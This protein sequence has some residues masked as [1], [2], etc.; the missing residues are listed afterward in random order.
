MA[1]NALLRAKLLSKLYPED[2]FSEVYTPGTYGGGGK[3]AC[4]M[5][6]PAVGTYDMHVQALLSS[7]NAEL[8]SMNADVVTMMEI[9]TDAKSHGR[10]RGE[11]GNAGYKVSVVECQTVTSPRILPSA[12]HN[13]I[14]S[15][16]EHKEVM[17]G[18]PGM[19]EMNVSV[20]I[21][22]IVARLK[23]TNSVWSKLVRTPNEKRSGMI[24]KKLAGMRFEMERYR[25]ALK[26]LPLLFEGG[27]QTVYSAIHDCLADAVL[28]IRAVR[29]LAKRHGAPTF[30]V[31]MEPMCTLYKFAYEAL[32][33][34]ERV[35]NE[36]GTQVHMFCPEMYS[37]VLALTHEAITPL[38]A[39]VPEAKT[40]GF[41]FT[42]KRFREYMLEASIS[43]HENN[44]LGIGF[45][46]HKNVD[47]DE[48]DAFFVKCDCTG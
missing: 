48:F 44:M 32:D 16:E 9:V 37:T 36:V 6:L 39:P 3:G 46:D 34:L 35:N 23:N 10:W 42:Q 41:T 5:P 12:V 14:I 4:M 17:C 47:D 18:I 45:P 31:N 43:T 7:A 15:E 28:Y 8:V 13:I 21:S 29:I 20:M 26:H 24:L 22:D 19:G 25:S 30:E 2:H 38:Q 1:E 27:M 40:V 11:K 33:V